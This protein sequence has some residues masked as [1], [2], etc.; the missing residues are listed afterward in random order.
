LN[1]ARAIENGVFVIAPCSTGKVPG[2]GEAYGHSLVVNPWGEV[3]AD[4]GVEPG[5]IHA[6]IDLEEVLD[7]RKK[8]P[9]LSH[10]RLFE[11]VVEYQNKR[12]VA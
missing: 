10:D 4:G 7:A 9:S 5:I 6:I 11:T 12:I 1:R 2:G 3:V 8:I